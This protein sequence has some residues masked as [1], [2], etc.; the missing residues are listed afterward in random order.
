M[1]KIFG[2]SSLLLA[3]FANANPLVGSWQFVEGKYAT[4]EGY[5]TAKA[6]ELT[7]VKLIT[8]THFSYITQKNGNF[9]YAGGGKYVLQDQQFIE[10]FSYGNVPS[11]QGK[12]M[13]FDYK[14]DGDLWHHTLYE[15]GKL[16]EAEIWQRIK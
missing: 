16:V 9:H 2:I 4:K 5:V 8:D 10:T 15:N 12:T 7:S 13:A 6:P 14:V 1:L 3:S 11:L